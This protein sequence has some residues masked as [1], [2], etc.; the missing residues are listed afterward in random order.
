MRLI[1]LCWTPRL[2]GVGA[3]C[4]AVRGGCAFLPVKGVVGGRV[5][6]GVVVGVAGSVK[7]EAVV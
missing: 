5:L 1:C 6:V 3:W 7:V 4:R 2:L